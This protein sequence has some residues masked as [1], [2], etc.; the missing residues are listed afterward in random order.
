[1]SVRVVIVGAGRTRQGL[2]P[3]V[4]K[5]LRAAGADVVGFVGHR[6]ETLATT[7][8]D[9]SAL[10]G[11]A[12]P[13]SLDLAEIAAA[14]QA[15]A[16][17][18]LCP[19]PHHS[20]YLEQAAHLG[21][22]ALC[23]K[24]LC[25]AGRDALGGVAAHV[26]AF[27]SRHLYL[28]ENCQWPQVIPSLER[29][30][31]PG[32]LGQAQGFAMGLAPEGE[33]VSMAIDSLSHPLSVLQAL[34]PGPAQVLDPRVQGQGRPGPRQVHFTFATP[35]RRLECRVELAHTQERPRPAWLEFD[36]IRAQRL[37]RERDYAI[38]L[39]SGPAQVPVPD[40]LEAHLA[41]FVRTLEGVLAGETPPDP[42]PIEHRAGFLNQLLAAFPPEDL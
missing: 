10:L 32:L 36:G 19:A 17:A 21:L 38:F 9:L 15:N 41:G 39:R 37:I 11:H 30:L 4:A 2:G 42:A 6:A 12:C 16:V 3:F 28:E 35:V 40:P 26:H 5:Y 22:H 23:E 7:A 20:A 27:R 29:L 8:A 24:P 18:I 31:P 33:G 25:I 34:C 1:M 14:R 13:G